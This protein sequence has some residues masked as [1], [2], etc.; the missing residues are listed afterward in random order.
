MDLNNQ[1]HRERLIQDTTTNPK[2]SGG[3]IPS[4]GGEWCA[5]AGEGV[6]AAR[7]DFNSDSLSNLALVVAWWLILC[8]WDCDF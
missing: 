6:E 1:V 7:G 2:Y 3:L 8:V 5:R 4:H